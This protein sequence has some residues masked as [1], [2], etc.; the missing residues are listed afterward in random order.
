MFFQLLHELIHF[1]V[2]LFQFACVCE[3]RKDPGEVWKAVMDEEAMPRA[4]KDLLVV[5]SN[6]KMG[7]FVSNFDTNPNLIIYN[8]AP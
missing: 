1:D 7:R 3:A 6:S 5:D 4:I 8:H 2:L